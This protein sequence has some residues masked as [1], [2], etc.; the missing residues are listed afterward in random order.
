MG[1]IAAFDI[2]IASVGW[3]IIEKESEMVIE[4]GSNIFPEASAAGNQM[5]FAMR[6]QMAL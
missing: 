1:H 6:R 3:A 2:G 4:A 5:R